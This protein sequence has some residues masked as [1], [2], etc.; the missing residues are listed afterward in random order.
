MIIERYHNL[1]I[2]EIKNH[3][4]Q[5]KWFSSLFKGVRLVNEALSHRLSS[6]IIELVERYETS[7]QECEA[8]VNSYE[9][10]V[11]S[12]LERMGFV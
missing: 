9:E 7:L 8:E 5:G 11:K 3:I 1:T 2:A 12:H 10:K 4:I 6:R